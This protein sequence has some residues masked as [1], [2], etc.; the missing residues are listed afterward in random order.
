MSEVHAIRR[1][2]PKI[3]G[4]PNRLVSQDSSIGI[5]PT[6]AQ[7]TNTEIDDDDLEVSAEQMAAHMDDLPEPPRPKLPQS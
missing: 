5:P 4:C 2:Q 7:M 1:L 6:G 3:G